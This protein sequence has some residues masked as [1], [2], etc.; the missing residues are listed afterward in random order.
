MDTR[1]SLEEEQNTEHRGQWGSQD[2]IREKDFAAVRRC[3]SY[4]SLRRPTFHV[5]CPLPPHP[6]KPHASPHLAELGHKS[7]IL[8]GRVQSKKRAGE[9]RRATVLTALLMHSYPCFATT[10]WLFPQ[11][12]TTPCS[13]CARAGSMDRFRRVETHG[14]G[15]RC[16]CRR[17]N[18]S[19]Q[20]DQFV[21]GWMLPVFC[22][23]S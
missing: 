17:A 21:C 20:K 16:H 7:G 2:T 15:R 14:G 12:A 22:R 9:T 1:E 6:Q 19:G 11:N 23:R 10:C 5:L 3:R 4:I 18:L 13:P 8:W